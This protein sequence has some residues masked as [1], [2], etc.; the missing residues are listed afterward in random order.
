MPNCQA[1]EFT[2]PLKPQAAQRSRST[3]KRA[4]PPLMPT[5]AA[6]W[7][8]SASAWVL[9]IGLTLKVIGRGLGL[10]P[11]LIPKKFS[12]LISNLAIVE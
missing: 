7:K 9:V 11:E 10:S 2:P 8:A 1:I 4:L 5:S 6:C 12:P 3:I